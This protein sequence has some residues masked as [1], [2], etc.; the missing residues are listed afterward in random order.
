M[1]RRRLS[2]LLC[3]AALAAFVQAENPK[4]VRYCRFKTGEAVVYGIVDGERIIELDGDLFGKW[5]KTDKTHKLSSVKLLAPC[6]PTQVFAMAGNYKSH[7]GA[8]DTVTTITT[9]TKLTT[10]KGGE[11]KEESKTTVDINKPGVVP[12]KFQIPQLFIKTASC[13]SATG[14]DIVIPPGT[15]RVDYEGEMVVVIGKTAKN[16]SEK[17]AL[18]YVVGVT[19]GNDVS[20][21]DWQKGD[22]QWWRAKGSDTFGPIGPFILS[23]VNYDNLSLKTRLNGKIVQDCNT[24]EL[25]QDTARIVSFVSKHVTLKPGDVI[26][27]GTSGVTQPINPGDEVEVELEGAGILR[28]KVTGSK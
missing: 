9:I 25:I 14:D 20:A 27:T 22:V 19:P 7:L 21:R 13:I 8:D 3:L 16:V 1:M 4:G 10:S 11:T 12:P 26:F 17:E 23:G 24:K 2:A 5:K 6:Q 18:D 28:N 15:K